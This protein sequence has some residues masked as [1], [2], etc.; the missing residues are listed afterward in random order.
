[1]EAVHGLLGGP[2]A[3]HGSSL[4]DAVPRVTGPKERQHMWGLLEDR[5]IAPK[6]SPLPVPSSASA[7]GSLE[8]G[9]MRPRDVW[10]ERELLQGQ[11]PRRGELFNQ[12]QSPVAKSPLARRSSKAPHLSTSPA[13]ARKS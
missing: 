4:P 7:P 1:M 3:R 11:V 13:G 9:W 5:M 8:S 12:A 6:P 2:A 10:A